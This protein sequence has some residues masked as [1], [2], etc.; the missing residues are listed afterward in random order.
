MKHW[1]LISL[2][3][4]WSLL[5]WLGLAREGATTQSATYYADA[6]EATGRF[7]ERLA[8]LD[9]GALKADQLRA[10]W[11]VQSDQPSLA[12]LV[13]GAGWAAF[14]RWMD[15]LTAM[16]VPLFLLGLA[17]PWLVYRLAERVAGRFAGWLAAL[18]ALSAPGWPQA[19]HSIGEEG[20]LAFTITLLAWAAV[21][22]L[23]S[24]AWRWGSL[25]A[26]G[27][28]IDTHHQGLWLWLGV[29]VGVL[30]C[31]HRPAEADPAS[32]ERGGLQGL[33]LPW[34]VLAM[35]LV[36]MLLLFA[37][38][39]WLW[40]QGPKALESFLLQ[41]FRETH[42]PFAFAGTLHVQG[43]SGNA[44]PWYAGLSLF[45]WRLPLA[46]LLGFLAGAWGVVRHGLRG[47]DERWRGLVVPACVLAMALL[48]DCL[49]GTP[50]YRHLHLEVAL[51]PLAAVLAAVGLVALAAPL[52]RTLGRR[53]APGMLLAWLLPAGLAG[54]SLAEYLAQLP[55]E[56]FF[57]NALSDGAWD[58]GTRGS[59]VQVEPVLLDTWLRET[60]RVHP[61]P[62]RLAILPR[63]DGYARV[64]G[65][66]QRAGRLPAGLTP[67][68]LPKAD[69]VG[70]GAMP[71]AGEEKAIQA[72]TKGRREV[73]RAG[74][75]GA[76]L[77]TLWCNKEKK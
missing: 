36:G 30:A 17:T 4:A 15:P 8:T 47:T 25:L 72:A 41:P 20:V 75:G 69:C 46:T 65:T 11:G 34:H 39:P 51:L 23:E 53:W 67:S 29:L 31:L 66:L 76:R 18:L 56:P 77:F 5:F 22:S 3:A 9:F 2:L 32:L 10:T 35:P 37:L 21:R 44:P 60:A 58:G 24:R 13:M 43:A 57:R 74:L 54:A 55:Y 64:L 63:T 61:G 26:M 6:A 50:W 71:E 7:L 62:T 16:V 28:V 73:L 12:R 68:P 70:V 38:W 14:H 49:N 27:L 42:P 40:V 19:V 45:Y 1:P 33:R 48:V 52:A 59:T